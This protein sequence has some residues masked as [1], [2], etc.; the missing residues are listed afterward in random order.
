MII[1]IDNDTASLDYD[2]LTQL[3]GFEYLLRFIWSDR[4]LCWYMNIAD[5]DGNPLA[6]GIRL[7]CGVPLLRGFADPRLPPGMLYVTNLAG[8]DVD[9]SQPSDLQTNFPLCYL[10]SDDPILT[11]G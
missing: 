9:L 2:Q 11:G 5:Q 8:T 6:Y 10:T 1:I 4:E 7:V 3:E